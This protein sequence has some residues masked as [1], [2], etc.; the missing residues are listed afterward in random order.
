MLYIFLHSKRSAR[1]IAASG[2][3]AK[4]RNWQYMIWSVKWKTLSYS[5]SV[6]AYLFSS[7]GYYCRV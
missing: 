2:C 1:Q 5:R 4:S 6:T 7:S 3:S